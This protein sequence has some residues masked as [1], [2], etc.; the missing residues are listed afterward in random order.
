MEAVG[1]ARRQL[2]WSAKKRC[3]K[4]GWMWCGTA[5]ILVPF[6]GRGGEVNQQEVVSRRRS[7]ISIEQFREGERKW[8]GKSDEQHW[9]GK[10]T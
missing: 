4:R 10:G 5:S 1:G 9:K 7:M 6:I 3:Y 8:G 2:D